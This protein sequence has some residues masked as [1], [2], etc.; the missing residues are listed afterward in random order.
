MRNLEHVKIPGEERKPDSATERV[1]EKHRVQDKIESA[2]E[3]ASELRQRAWI[4]TRYCKECEKRASSMQALDNA[5]TDE[6][7]LGHMKVS[8]TDECEIEGDEWK[9]L[10]DQA[11]EPCQKKYEAV[12]AQYDRD[13]AIFLTNGGTKEKGNAALRKETLQ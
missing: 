9:K 3:I 13:P 8:E 1:L 10:S 6:N 7:V 4:T 5:K 12:K 2:T 11:K